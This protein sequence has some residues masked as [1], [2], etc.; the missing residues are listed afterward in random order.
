MVQKIV[1]KAEDFPRNM[2]F[3]DFSDN[4]TE[5]I[6]LQ[7]MLQDMGIKPIPMSS[8]DTIF[9]VDKTKVKIGDR[10]K[11]EN[12]IVDKVYYKPKKWW[13]WFKKRKQIGYTVRWL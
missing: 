6:I 11:N 3:A 9:I 4:I 7:Q 8:G 2:P 1:I 13:Q 10:Y 12:A 5:N